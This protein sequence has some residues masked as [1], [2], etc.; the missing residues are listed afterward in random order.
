MAIIMKHWYSDNPKVSF[1]VRYVQSSVPKK[2][3]FMVTTPFRTAIVPID[4]SDED[5][6]TG[7]KANFRNEI[8][9]GDREGLQFSCEPPTRENMR[10]FSVFLKSRGL[11]GANLNYCDNPHAFVT[12]GHRN[13]K[14]FASHL[15][16]LSPLQKRAR[17]IYSATA[18]FGAVEPDDGESQRKIVGTANRWLHYHDMRHFRD[19]GAVLYDFG[20]LGNETSG[21]KK[22][23]GINKFKMGFGSL[24][25]I[26]YNQDPIWLYLIS[27]LYSYVRKLL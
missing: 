8:R 15:I 27:R 19:L 21:G 22:V 20:G 2:L 12:L 13:T 6:F 10:C 24:E 18:P 23:E 3:P 9:R 26:E 7:F 16:I 25:V 14:F 11:G 4:R 5:I 17:L 1:R